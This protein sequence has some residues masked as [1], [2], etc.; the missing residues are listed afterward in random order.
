VVVYFFVTVIWTWAVP[1]APSVS[2]TVTFTVNVPVFGYLW[3][4]VLPPVAGLLPSR[5]RSCR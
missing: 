2:V 4:A 3:L 5:S 1:V